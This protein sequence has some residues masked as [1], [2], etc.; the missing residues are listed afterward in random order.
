MPSEV[1][2]PCAVLL[3]SGLVFS[4]ATRTANI[5]CRVVAETRATS[6]ISFA[7]DRNAYAE[8]DMTTPVHMF[9]IE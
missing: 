8:G 1:M 4:L 7:L 9:G 5:L 6:A 2:E 3:S